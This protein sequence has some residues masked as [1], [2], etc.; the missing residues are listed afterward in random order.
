MPFNK[1][2]FAGKGTN[3]EFTLITSII[4]C[5]VILFTGGLAAIIAIKALTGQVNTRYLLYGLR[6]DGTHYFSPERV[7][8]LVATIAVAM[9]YVMLSQHS[10]AGTMPNLPDGSL[11]VLGLSHAVYL[12]GKS[13]TSML[14]T[15]KS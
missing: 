10:E 8:L 9:Q 15:N 4:R 1:P 6:R 7:Q 3:M 2:K 5:E 14:T 11:Q 12:G 13:W